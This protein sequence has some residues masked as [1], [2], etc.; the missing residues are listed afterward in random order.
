MNGLLRTLLVAG[1]ALGLV[2]L[3]A[4]VSPPAAGT[5]PVHLTMIANGMILFDGK[6]LDR[7]ALA[8]ALKRQGV[9]ADTP[10]LV[11]IPESTPMS[12]V[13]GLASQL[14]SAGYRR[15]VFTSPR[16]ADVVR[17]PRSAAR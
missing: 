6:A 5:D 3:P 1:I 2:S 10:L 11:A 4:C 16:H 8:H 14:A 7:K 12:E 9:S 13:T 15:V 17:N